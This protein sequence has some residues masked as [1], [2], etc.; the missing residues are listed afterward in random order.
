MDVCGLVEF[1]G[2]FV[3]VNEG[4]DIFVVFWSSCSGMGFDII[5]WVNKGM[6]VN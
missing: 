3:G 1:I 2:D 5:V 4:E 6:G